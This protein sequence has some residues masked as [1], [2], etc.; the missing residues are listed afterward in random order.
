MLGS[1]HTENELNLICI[2][3]TRWKPLHLQNGITGEHFT[4][5]QGRQQSSYSRRM[6]EC[7]IPITEG[8]WQFLLTCLWKTEVCYSFALLNF[9]RCPLSGTIKHRGL[10]SYSTSAKPWQ[11]VLGVLTLLWR[12]RWM[13]FVYIW[14]EYQVC[15]YWSFNICF[16]LLSVFNDC[17][18]S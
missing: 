2:K 6:L 3:Q 7:H 18:I 1:N 16:Y 9:Q 4:V 8:I 14:T 12:C 11:L 15:S 10:T 13:D 5:V 17:N